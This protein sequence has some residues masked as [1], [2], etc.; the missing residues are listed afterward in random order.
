MAK[1]KIIIDIDG[2][3]YSSRFTTLMR[4][5]VAIIKIAAF[6]D[7]GFVAARPW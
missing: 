4:M 7:F 1:F 5:G 2:N 6:D 3:T